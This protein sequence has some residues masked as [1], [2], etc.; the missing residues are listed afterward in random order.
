[1]HNSGNSHLANQWPDEI[2]SL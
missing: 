2:P 1:M